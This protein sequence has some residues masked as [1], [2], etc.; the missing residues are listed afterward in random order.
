MLSAV[1]EELYQLEIR[2]KSI[3]VFGI[4]EREEMVC[5]KLLEEMRATA[6]FQ[7]YRTGPKVAG[8]Q[9]TLI[10]KLQTAVQR[11]K[12]LENEKNL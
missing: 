1:H 11:D 9:Q 10:M 5:R 8:R 3:A 12:V 6:V 7:C 2:K 4:Q